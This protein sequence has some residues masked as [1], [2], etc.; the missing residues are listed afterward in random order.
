MEIHQLTYFV[1]VAE[2]GGFS[3]AAERCNVAQP[4]LSQQIIKLEQELGQPLFER[5]G[6]KVVLTD[7]GRMLLPRANAILAELQDIRH[8]LDQE[9]DT[10]QGT[11]SV[12]FI[13]TIAPFVL[14]LIIHRF[15]QTLPQAALTVQEDFTD[16]LIRDLIDGKL[17]VGIMSL[18]IH[19]KL[20]KTQELLTEPLLVASSRRY[21]ISARTSI[22]VK[23]LDDF[24]FIALSEV[25]CLGEQVQAFCYQQHVNLQIVCHTAQLSTVQSCIALGLGVSLVPQALALSDP[26]DE[27]VYRPVSDVVPQRKIVAATHAGRL[28]SFLAREFIKMVREEYPARQDT[29]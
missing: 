27:I 10:G 17:D 6:R 5:L 15:R 4:S 12:G 9:V 23:E 18:P 26:L 13:P 20:I 28:P 25:H 1:A 19:N 22:R 11:L 3:R 14:P 21:D 24:P 7:T 8:G 16:N 2:T 29:S